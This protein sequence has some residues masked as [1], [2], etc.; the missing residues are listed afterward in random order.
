MVIH[1]DV[2]SVF[3]EPWQVKQERIRATS[4][5]GSHPNWRLLSV[6]VKS[7][8]DLRQ[9]QLAL[10]LISEMQKIWQKAKVDVWVYPF[11][12]L[13]TSDQAGLV[14][15]IPDSISIHSIKKDGYSRQLNTSGIAYTLY[16]HFCKEFGPPG[17]PIFL[18]AQDKF[19]R[20]VAGYSV[21]CYLLQIKDRHNGNILLDHQGY[22]T[23]I[24]F[25]FMLSN[26]PGSVGFELAPF[27]L[28]QEYIDVLGGMFSE[29]FKEFRELLKQ[30]FL[31][32]RKRSEVILALVEIMEKGDLI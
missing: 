25:G 31:A 27:K 22:C 20:S 12:I 23:H 21:I 14:E 11:Q 3:K 19:M 32:L 26:S 13:I 28:P 16:D 24:D 8:S 10:Q 30:A 5:F 15:T 18:D 2:A 1:F 7:G 29:K 4:P 17:S 9:E 6:I